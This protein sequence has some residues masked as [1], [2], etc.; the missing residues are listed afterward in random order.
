MQAATHSPAH[1]TEAT[2][3]EPWYKHTFRRNVI[4]MHITADDPSFMS[5]FD[6]EKY[7]PRPLT[8]ACHMSSMFSG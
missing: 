8:A 4:D 2:P 6:A 1:R 7:V 5:E 3:G